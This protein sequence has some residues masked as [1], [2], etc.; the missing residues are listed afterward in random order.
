MA[1]IIGI[2]IGINRQYRVTSGGGG[3]ARTIDSVVVGALSSFSL[4]VTITADGEVGD[5]VYWVLL[6]SAATA[7]NDDEVVAGTAAGGGAATDNGSFAWGTSSATLVS[8]IARA[9]Y[10]LYV[11]I[12]NGTTNS[13]VGTPASAFEVDTTSSILTSESFTDGGAEDVDWAFTSNENVNYRVSLWADGSTPS[14]AEI[15]SGTGS[16]ATVTGSAD[17]SVAETGT[18]ASGDGT[19]V[20]TIW[21]QDI[22]G[23][24]YTETY[25]DVT[26]AVANPLLT[27][28]GR[29]YHFAFDDVAVS[30]S[31]VTSV[32]DIPGGIVDLSSI[33]AFAAPTKTGTGPL[34]F[35]V[36]PARVIQT[37]TGNAAY[38][39]LGQ[40]MRG[41]GSNA[42]RLFLVV[43]AA[44]LPTT[45]ALFFTESLDFN[46]NGAIQFGASLSGG[47]I[48]AH[49]G[50]TSTGGAAATSSTTVTSSINGVSTGKC[51]VEWHI[52]QTT[53]EV[54]IDGVSIGSG[55]TTAA[56][57]PN[58]ASAFVNLGGRAN[59]STVQG[60][61]GGDFYEFFATTTADSTFAATVR[62]HLSTRHGL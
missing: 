10:R 25:A 1:P 36:S 26:V 42:A 21:V 37:P 14:A 57:F 28:A 61:A 16:I 58:P 33:G 15:E 18:L 7:P 24:E 2:G 46:A 62:S 4:P 56:N 11:V 45:T 27:D 23:N 3:I 47:N 35:A 9:N 44:T 22:Y 20:P 40:H 32:N 5:T 59:A 12:R 29:L 34:V 48:R 6:P 49:I 43:D 51:I 19:F 53:W 38:R 13:N 41:G 30:G 8:G 52:T 55:T 50:M 60:A 54:F 31:N 39:L 17:A